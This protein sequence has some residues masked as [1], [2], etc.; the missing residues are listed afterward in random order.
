MR[1][2]SRRLRLDEVVAEGEEEG[3]GSRDFDSLESES[4]VVVAGAEVHMADVMTPQPKPASDGAVSADIGDAFCS[5]EGVV[6]LQTVGFRG[7]L[8]KC[9]QA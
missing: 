2:Q 9:A 6:F 7:V 8:R 4:E 5:R 3:T 1:A